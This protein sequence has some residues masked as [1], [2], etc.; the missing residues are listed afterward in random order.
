VE[1]PED[2][3]TDAG[4]F[5]ADPEKYDKEAR[6]KNWKPGTAVQLMEV[7]ARLSG[8]EPFD[9][10][11]VEAAVRGTAEALSVGASRLIHPLRLALTGVSKGPGLFE[12]M[13]VL[14]KETCLRRIERA[15]AV[16]G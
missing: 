10:A 2:F 16:L 9:H 8:L 13:A 4:Y 6:T 5:F 15:C 11:S 1:R 3:A 12:L 7:R 14:G